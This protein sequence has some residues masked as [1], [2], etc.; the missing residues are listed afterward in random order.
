MAVG[1]EATMKLSRT[2]VYAVHAMLQMAQ[3]TSGEPISRSQ[4]A[5]AGP[6]PERFLLEILHSLT[7]RGLVRSIR[8]VEGGFTLARS[9]EQ[10]TLRDIFEAFDYPPRPF[11]PTVEGQPL[12]IREQLLTSLG[13]ASTAALGE[14]EKLTLAELRRNGL[15]NRLSHNGDASVQNGNAANHNGDA[16][17]HN[18]DA[19]NRNGDASNRNGDSSNHNGHASNHNGSASIQTTNRSANS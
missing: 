13:Q 4:L 7:A 15:A 11:V 14:L 5:A 12:A 3:A 1:K 17:N 9:P 16:S 10:V 8:G 18:G 6:L 2:I 19:S